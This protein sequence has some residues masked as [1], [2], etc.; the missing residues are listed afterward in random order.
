[1]E[2]EERKKGKGREAESNALHPVD[3]ADSESEAPQKGANGV[4]GN[5]PKKKQET[6]TLNPERYQTLMGLSKLVEFRHSGMPRL[7][8]ELKAF[9]QE[10]V[11]SRKS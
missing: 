5:V 7:F 4:S 8:E 10:Q 2:R 1:M 6:F 9:N 3:D 11:E